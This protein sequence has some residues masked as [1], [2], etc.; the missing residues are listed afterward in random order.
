MTK[1][2]VVIPVWNRESTILTAVRSV[3]AQTYHEL[4]VLVVDNASTDGTFEAV[5]GLGDSRVR[6]LR[7]NRNLGASGG[8]NVGIAEATGGLIGLLDSDDVL[9]PNWLQVLTSLCENP[10]VAVASCGAAIFHGNGTFAKVVVPYVHGPAFMG[11]K[12][13]IQAGTFLVRSEVIRAVGGFDERL[14]YSENTELALRLTK[15]AAA[16]GLLFAS[17]DRSLMRWNLATSPKYRMEDRAEACRIVLAEHGEQLRRQRRMYGSYAAQLGTW[18]ARLGDLPAARRS[19]RQAW[20]ADPRT[21]RHGLRLAAASSQS[22]ADHLWHRQ[23]RENGQS[24]LEG[25]SKAPSN[26]QGPRA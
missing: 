13:S 2:S 22:I 18:Q 26:D 10:R 17:S 14:R 6:V 23:N 12:M 25:D 16:N 8:R 24:Q 19:F 11:T 5:S 4:E 3:L 21:L 15:H 7:Q 1:A 9:D 20:S